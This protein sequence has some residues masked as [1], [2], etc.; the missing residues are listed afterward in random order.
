MISQKGVVMRFKGLF[1]SFSLIGPTGFIR[2]TW[3]VAFVVAITTVSAS[4]AP[5]AVRIGTRS[6]VVDTALDFHSGSGNYVSVLRYDTVSDDCFSV[7]LSTDEG[8]TW[9]ESYEYC[10]GQELESDIGAVV[11]GDFLYV[12]YVMETAVDTARL[13]RFRMSDGAVDPIYGSQT[14][15]TAAVGESI[16]DVDVCSNADTF[17]DRLYF[18]A[19]HAGAIRSFWTDELGGTGPEPWHE[20]ATAFTNVW[21]VLGVTSN[22]N[23][24]AGSGYHP[25]VLYVADGFD[26]GVWRYHPV[27][28]ASNILDSAAYGSPSGIS[29]YNDYVAV[30]YWNQ[31]YE[32]KSCLSDDGGLTFACEQVQGDGHGFTGDMAARNGAGIAE[33]V[34]FN[35]DQPCWYRHQDYGGTWSNDV[36]CTEI[37][38]DGE[39]PISLESL[40]PHNQ[41]SYGAVVVSNDP[42]AGSAYFIRSPVV[43]ADEF[44][45]SNT[46][47]WSATVQ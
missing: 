32:M 29:A 2:R 13:M 5:A 45:S 19:T 44:E 33:M 14:V 27:H 7:N 17:D 47:A 10:T 41:F 20:L 28:S 6:D 43:F 18:F 30:N 42:V 39:S 36:V 25:M 34:V 37:S 40:P 16:W 4:W 12:A 11:S 1:G 46:S 8:S 31:N 23:Y 9:T 21:W 38:V 35:N 24:A 26:L 3:A 15:L 22:E